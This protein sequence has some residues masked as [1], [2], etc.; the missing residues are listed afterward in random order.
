MS[1]WVH[2]ILPPLW[3]LRDSSNYHPWSQF[4]QVHACLSQSKRSLCIVAAPR[5]RSAASADFGEAGVERQVGAGIRP[6]TP[7]GLSVG[8]PASAQPLPLL[9]GVSDIT[10]SQDDDLTLGYQTQPL[11]GQHDEETGWGDTSSA[12]RCHRGSVLLPVQL[13]VRWNEMISDNIRQDEM[14][15]DEILNLR[16][17]IHDTVWIFFKGLVLWGAQTGRVQLIVLWCSEASEGT[18]VNRVLFLLQVR[19]N[20]PG[21]FSRFLTWR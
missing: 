19:K 11:R 9:G 4:L 13:Q 3:G 6:E 15:W 20:H 5:R 17:E 16:G 1:S 12:Q 18:R 8:Q 7:G 10:A 2:I 21:V 14:R